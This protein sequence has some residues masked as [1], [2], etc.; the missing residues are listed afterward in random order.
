MAASK[1]EAQF[2]TTNST[3]AAGLLARARYYAT[4]VVAALCFLILGLPLIPAGYVLRRFFGVR[5]F[6]YP[7]GRFGA[8]L[9]LKTA[10]ARVHASGYQYLDAQQSYVF[11]ANHQSN[12]DPPLLFAYLGRNPGFLAKQELFRIPVFKQG[13]TLIDAVPINR[14]N[15][16]AAIASTQAA[17]DKLIA[18]RSYVGF[19]EGTR[20]VD[21]GLKEFKKGIFFM[22]LVA[23]VPV[24]PVVIND[25]RLVMRKGAK[26]CQPHDVSME[27][28]PPVSTEGYSEAGID[29]LITKV[30]EQMS[31][32]ARAD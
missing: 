10:G 21:G 26:H 4:F 9:Y 13:I 12:L 5:D 29:D 31:A 6:I 7:F 19:P 15:R 23:R 14:S 24:V 22:A 25:T 1:E 8:R 17:A 11:V 20:S 2:S 30:R 16:E 18:G 3:E 32:R 27:I 28:L